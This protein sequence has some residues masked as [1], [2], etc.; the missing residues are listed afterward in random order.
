[1]KEIVTDVIVLLDGQNGGFFSYMP[2]EQAQQ[3]QSVGLSQSEQVILRETEDRQI[4]EAL[5]TGE[6]CITD[7][8]VRL[9]PNCA[10]NLN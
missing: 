3:I 1:M 2:Y 6:V 9:E 4:P 10:F 5:K 8:L 7:I